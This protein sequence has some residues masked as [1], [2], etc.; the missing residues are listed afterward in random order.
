MASEVSHRFLA[1]D[2]VA[3]LGRWMRVIGCDTLIW[4]SG[5]DEEMLA[6]AEEEG[7]V[8]LTRHARLGSLRR[9]GP[10]IVVVEDE[11]PV[12]QLVQVVRALGLDLHARR[13]TRC[14]R[15]NGLVESVS[16]QDVQD[17]VPERSYGAFDQFW[18]CRECGHLYWRG[19]HFESM[20]QTL[21][22]VERQVGPVPP[23]DIPNAADRRT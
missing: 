15:C 4:R 22:W 7:R 1:D 8:V 12:S 11:N 5:R 16:K 17:Q 9:A 21:A 3:R 10:Q 13:Y 14:Q 20:E 18:R 2:M 6:A 23:A 19:D